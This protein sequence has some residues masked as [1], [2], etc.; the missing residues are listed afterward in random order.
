VVLYRENLQSTQGIS[1]N[2]TVPEQ[3]GIH[4]VNNSAPGALLFDN[5]TKY[6]SNIHLGELY[7]QD[8]QSHSAHPADHDS[9]PDLDL[10]IEVDWHTKASRLPVE[11]LDS[12]SKNYKLY[13]LNVMFTEAENITQRQ[14]KNGDP[15]TPDTPPINLE[16]ARGIE[17]TYHNDTST[18]YMFI[19]TKGAENPASAAPD[20]DGIG[21]VSA[22][23][24]ND[25][26][27]FGFGVLIF[28]DDHTS[29]SHSQSTHLQ[30]TMVHEIGHQLGAGR[31]D[32]GQGLNPF[33][34]VYSGSNADDTSERVGLGEAE[35]SVMIRDWDDILAKKPMNGDYIAFSI[36][37]LYSIEFRINAA[38]A[39]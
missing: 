37:E 13:G 17:E 9:E 16:D 3:I 18:S 32:D 30:K 27:S 39:P 19:T 2:N 24:G 8:T 11:L 36:E 1:G 22:T 15:P 31:A 6:R 12:V 21:G 28:T 5:G 14:L 23:N 26:Y 4:E 10:T 25:I 20:F 35:W 34:E 38:Y 7:W 33:T 29:Q